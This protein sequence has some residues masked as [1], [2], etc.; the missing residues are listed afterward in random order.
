MGGYK[1]RL[2]FVPVS[3]VSSVPAPIEEKAEMADYVKA[4]GAFTYLDSNAAIPVY[5]T[6]DKIS[7]KSSIQGEAD[8]RSYHNELG[9]FFPGYSTE[10]NAF[11]AA[12]CNTPCYI[13]FEDGKKQYIM[14]QEGYP[15]D[16]SPSFDGGMAPADS[17][18][19]SFTAVSD[20][21]VPIL[22]MDTPIDLDALF[23]PSSS[24]ET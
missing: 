23:N 7:F 24:S 22:E 18:G 17:K 2:A 11:A 8:C 21:E 15:C 5:S 10:A 19:W 14:G 16:V 1:G 3:F 20:S 6:K 13:V 4:T 9:F 12:V